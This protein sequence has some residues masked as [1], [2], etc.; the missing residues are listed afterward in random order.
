MAIKAVA[1]NPHREWLA[2]RQFERVEFAG[3]D[4]R[5]LEVGNVGLVYALFESENRVRLLAILRNNPA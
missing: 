4:I 3:N 1:A 2:G 5:L